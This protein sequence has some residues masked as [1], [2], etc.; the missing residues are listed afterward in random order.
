MN[1]KFKF[2]AGLI[3]PEG[4]ARFSLDALLLAAFSV[5]YLPTKIKARD[6]QAMEL[7]CGCGAVML[8]TALLC[9]T[10]SFTGFDNEAALIEAARKNAD[11]L[12]VSSRC[13]FYNKNV[14]NADSFQDFANNADLVMINPPWQMPGTGIK[15]QNP[16]R[17]KAFWATGDTFITF[18]QLA[19]I[20][21]KRRGRLCAIFPPTRLIDFFH[22]LDNSLLGL[23]LLLP[24]QSYHDTAVKRI[25]VLCQKNAASDFAFSAPLILRI[26][27]DDGL[28]ASY[29]PMAVNFCPWL[30]NE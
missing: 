16:V 9:P 10:G 28:S 11:K 13:R 8:G 27:S 3:Q 30:S 17:E 15:P 26:C 29:S 1:D 24:C 6:F 14:T 22:F 20:L 12:S 25:L 19:E 5:K 4:S 18:F 21:L 7:G 23:R 2:P